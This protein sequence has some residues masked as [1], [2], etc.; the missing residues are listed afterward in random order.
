MGQI[1][2]RDEEGNPTG[3]FGASDIQAS[4]GYVHKIFSWLLFGPSAGML[5]ETIAED[6]KSAYL[7]NTGLLLV[8]KSLSFGIACQ[9]IGSKF[10][11][12]SFTAHL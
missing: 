2:G 4:L 6:K 10:R 5:Q 12:G 3:D 11:R 9:N 8:G 7:G 1:E